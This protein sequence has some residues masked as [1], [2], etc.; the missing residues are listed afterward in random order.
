VTA[1][2]QW[3]EKGVAPEQLVGTGKSALDSAKPLRRPLCVY[4]QV[5]RYDGSGDP[6][7]AASFRCALPQ[8]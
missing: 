5:A 7:N 3:V 1:L 2:E 4:P 8:Q 6:A